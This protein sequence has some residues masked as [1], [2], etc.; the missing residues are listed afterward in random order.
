MDVMRSETR[1]KRRERDVASVEAAEGGLAR[2]DGE[3]TR[4]AVERSIDRLPDDQRE[5]LVLRLLGEKSYREIAEITGR[6]LGT[7]GWLVS[8]GLKALG[9]ELEPLLAGAPRTGP[10]SGV[11][12][13]QGESG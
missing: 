12:I 8:I 10:A 6:K 5:V 2:V 7:V 4:A 11:R 3:D 13:A 9:S 1:R